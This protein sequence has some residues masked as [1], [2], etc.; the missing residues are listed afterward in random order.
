MP[1]VEDTKTKQKKYLF[2]RSCSASVIFTEPTVAM[3]IL[4]Q[5]S[6]TKYT[7]DMEDTTKTFIQIPE[8]Q[9]HH[10]NKDIYIK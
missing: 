5:F 4:V 9:M 3:N 7:L 10:S 1:D 8:S 2:S 6:I